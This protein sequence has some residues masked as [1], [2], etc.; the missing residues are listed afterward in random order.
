MDPQR[1]LETNG[2]VERAQSGD[3]RAIEL[4][5]ERYILRVKNWTRG[6]IPTRARD[7]EDTHTVAHD[8]LVRVLLKTVDDENSIRS[9]FRA[10]VRRA[11]RNRLIDLGARKTPFR[12]ELSENEASSRIGKLEDMLATEFETDLQN[13]IQ[14]LPRD[15]R[16][17]LHLRFERELGY[18]RIAELLNLGSADAAR[19]RTNRVLARL[20]KDMNSAA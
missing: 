18:E 14:A 3:E 8:V 5:Y 10:Y 11:V 20:R 1:L 7:L 16:E 17:I 15:A 19:M 4:I 2:L 9:S 13:R 6:R 12:E